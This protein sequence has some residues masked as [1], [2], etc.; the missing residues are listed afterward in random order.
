MTRSADFIDGTILTA[1]MLLSDTAPPVPTATLLGGSSNSFA[2]VAIDASLGVTSGTLGIAATGV[3]AGTYT[4]ANVVVDAAG[5]IHAIASSSVTYTPARIATATSAAT[6][7]MSWAATDIQRV[8]L[9]VSTV[10][11]NSGAVDGQRCLIYI[12]QDGTGGRTYSFTGETTYGTT[13][14]ASTLSPSAA[15]KTDI[16]GLIYNGPAAKYQVVS[17]SQGY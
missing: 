14:P 2:S 11:T 12:T 7:S 1:A 10:I 3:T 17:Y 5:R 15:G 13:L 4:L 8:T 6:I 16:I 9:T